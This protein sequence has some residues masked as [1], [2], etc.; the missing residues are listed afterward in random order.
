M[1]T[2]A[3]TLEGIDALYGESH[4]LHGVSF[5]LNAGRVLALLGRNGAGK[6]TCMSAII[7]FLRPR[8]GAIRLFGEAIAGL[9]PEAIARK[10]VG[11][12]PQGRRVFAT[13]TVRE[14]LEVAR[15]GS[16]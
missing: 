1:N 10:G 13:L 16:A 6:S 3:L 15:R 12:V 2:E 14:N 5:S 8:A 4:V 7:G 11:L 9:A